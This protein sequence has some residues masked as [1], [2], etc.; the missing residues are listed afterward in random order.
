MKNTKTVIYEI[1]D[2]K[3]ALICL[4]AFL[5]VN[6]FSY[7][8]DKK[9]TKGYDYYRQ[10]QAVNLAKGLQKLHLNQDV[11]IALRGDSI[12]FGYNT[13]TEGED[14]LRRYD[15]DVSSDQNPSAAA[16]KDGYEGLFFYGS[17][18]L[19]KS[20]ANSQ[21]K[22]SVEQTGNGKPKR[23]EVQIPDVFI[24]SLNKVFEGHVSY[25][26]KVYTGDCAVSSYYRYTEE[27][28]ADIEVC[29]LGINDALAA[30]WGQ[31]YVGNVEEFFYWYSKLIERAIDAGSAWVIVTPVLLTTSV[32]YDV[33]NRTN[34]ALYRN[35]LYDIAALYGIPVISGDELT[36]N[37]SNKL[38]LDFGHL[39][40]AGNE[41]VGKRLAA[42]FIAGN[43]SNYLPV[44]NK[45]FIGIKPQEYPVNVAGNA[46]IEYSDKAPSFPALI[47]NNDL[48]DK[49]VNRISKGLAVFLNS[50][51]EKTGDE[52]ILFRQADLIA[53]G[54]GE[55]GSEEY[56]KAFN[57]HITFLKEKHSSEDGDKA[58]VTWA[59]YSE[60]DGLYV[61]P[62]VYG[63]NAKIKIELDFAEL[64]PEK[65]GYYLNL[66]SIEELK[67]EADKLKLN[68]ESNAAKEELI[69]NIK[70][71]KGYDK[72]SYEQAS[73][74]DI[75]RWTGKEKV[76][77][78]YAEPAVREVVVDGW[79]NSRTADNYLRITS[80]GWHTITVSAPEG[81]EVEIYGL[82]F[83]E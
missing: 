44:N 36:H 64:L 8:A 77:Y 43:L 16:K 27:N 39:T 34:V 55:I 82:N 57:D 17:H 54:K 9:K 68:Y 69:K 61:I 33:N 49:N 76:D 56:K 47:N 19:K 59:F 23:T 66:L 28:A 31:E 41:I 46:V 21:V 5:M 81:D 38:L 2:F 26:D 15:N 48:Y 78:L 71:A 53:R 72:A 30:F 24:Q 63:K 70:K 13:V 12:F 62:S 35:A 40:N 67:K 75:F 14:G 18:P 45:S 83:E 22:A 73:V 7:S 50:D 6:T 74:S 1:K 52:N 32:S 37:F 65:A 79:N 51:L 80:R 60:K 10:K 42:P 29:N 3:K 58:F 20:N 11:K 25:I 4:L